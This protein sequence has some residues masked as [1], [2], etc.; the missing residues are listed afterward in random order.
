MHACLLHIYDHAL[1]HLLFIVIYPRG[2]VMALCTCNF[3]QDKDRSFVMLASSVRLCSVLCFE[4][5]EW[6][7][8]CCS[9]KYGTVWYHPTSSKLWNLT[10]LSFV[11]FQGK[12]TGTSWNLFMCEASLFGLLCA[13]RRVQILRQQHVGRAGQMSLVQP[14]LVGAAG[15]TPFWGCLLVCPSK[16]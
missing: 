3:V 14:D 4:A 8:V 15:P 5:P 10:T 7:L 1:L 12:L 2:S 11:N 16:G 9:R 6:C 13:W